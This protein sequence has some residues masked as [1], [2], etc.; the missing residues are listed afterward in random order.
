[1]RSPNN[2]LE[3]IVQATIDPAEFIT[4]TEAVNRGYG[5]RSTIIR[6]IADGI[7]LSMKIDG[8]TY[9][10]E[11]DIIEYKREQA[12]GSLNTRLVYLNLEDKLKQ[13]APV[14]SA[15]QKQQLTEL[16]SQ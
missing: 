12:A 7:V 15:E 16:L 13:F 8:K 11:S 4:L 3:Q 10:R 5:A 6:W 1:M 9:V 14:F 2:S